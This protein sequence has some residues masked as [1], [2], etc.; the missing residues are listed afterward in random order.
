MVSDYIEVGDS[1]GDNNFDRKWCLSVRPSVRPSVFNGRENGWELRAH[2]WH[3]DR[4]GGGEGFG[5]KKFPKS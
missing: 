3:D 4:V 5:Q 2:I 1:H